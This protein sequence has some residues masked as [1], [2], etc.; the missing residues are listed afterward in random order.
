MGATEL[1]FGW[2]SPRWVKVIAVALSL[3]V[4]V[5]LWQVMR[6]PIVVDSPIFARQ[7]SALVLATVVLSPHFFI[8]D[9]VIL[10]LPMLLIV[11]SFG[12]GEWRTHSI[13][14][15][16]GLVLLALFAI[17]GLCSEIAGATRIQPSIALIIAAIV[18]IGM[19]NQKVDAHAGPVRN[20][21]E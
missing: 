6:G 8:Y 10:L 11:S 15:S 13:N 1:L 16:L 3:L 9:L 17:A 18:L 21:G 4:V 7:F 20:G 2:V 5:V 19:T 12:S 14:Q